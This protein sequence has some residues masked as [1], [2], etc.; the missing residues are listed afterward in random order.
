MSINLY[1]KKTINN[2]PVLEELL[3]KSTDTVD[4]KPLVY[5]STTDN[6]KS[7]DNLNVNSVT[8]SCFH[9]PLDGTAKNATCFNDK[10]YAEACADILSGCA[11]DSNKLNGKTYSEVCSDILS[12][13]AANATCFAG[14]TCT[15]WKD[16]IK[17]T[18][19]DNAALATNATCFNGCT[20]SE[21][22]TDI[23]NGLATQACADAIQNC[24]DFIQSC[25]SAIESKIPA[26]ASASNQL[27]DKDFVN[28][29]IT[30]NTANF[31]GTYACVAELPTTG[32]TNNDYAFICSLN[33]TT[34]NYIYDRYKWVASDSCWV[35]EYELNTTGFT[36]EQLASINSGI[37]DTLVAKITD[38]YDNTVTICMNDECKGSFSLNQ[39]TDVCIDLGCTI[40]NATCFNSCTYAQAKADIRNY[41]PSYATCTLCPIIHASD[42]TVNTQHIIPF[43]EY[44]HTTNDE[45]PLNCDS[46]LYYVTV[47]QRLHTKNLCVSC[48][49][50]IGS[51]HILCL[52]TYNT[53]DGKACEACCSNCAYS[54]FTSGSDNTRKLISSTCGWST[55]LQTNIDYCLDSNTLSN[56]NIDISGCS[57]KSKTACFTG[58]VDIDCNVNIGGDLNVTGTLTGTAKNAT[59]FNG[60]TYSQAKTDILSG[61]AASAT[62]ATCFG[63][64]TYACAKADFRSGLISDIGIDV[65]CG[66][67]C[68]CTLNNGST[69]ALSANAFNENAT[70]STDDYPGV[71]CTGTSN[72]VVETMVCCAK[73]VRRNQATTG[74]CHLALFSDKTAI[75]NADA[76]VSNACELTYQPATGVLNVRKVCQCVDS[77]HTLVGNPNGTTKYM[78]IKLA[79]MNTV[80]SSNFNAHL[81]FDV[82]GNRVEMDV[83]GSGEEGAVVTRTSRTSDYAITRYLPGAYDST[84]KT[85]T[86]YVEFKGY[87]NIQVTS[88]TPIVSITVLDEAP[89]GTFVDIPFANRTSYINTSSTNAEYPLVFSTCC[90]T[91][92]AGNRTLYNDSANNLMYNPS[93]NTLT[94]CC[95]K[96]ASRVIAGSPLSC[97]STQTGNAGTGVCSG[98]MEIFGSTPF[99]DFHHNNTCADCSHRL[100]ANNGYLRVTASNATGC[101]AATQSANFDFCSDGTFDTQKL[102]N[103]VRYRFVSKKTDNGGRTT[104]HLLYD[105][106]CAV[107]CANCAY[108]INGTAYS[109]RTPSNT[110]ALQYLD[111]IDFATFMPYGNSGVAN[112]QVRIY[113]RNS[114]TVSTLN[115]VI[116]TRNDGR[117]YAGMLI[118]GS[119]RQVSYD[120]MGS[121]G[122]ICEACLG[123]DNVY[124]D[125]SGYTYTIAKEGSLAEITS[126]VSN[127]TNATCFGGC[128]Y[129]EAKTDILSGNASCARSVC[130]L[131]ATAGTYQL[132][133][134]SDITPTSNAELRVSS[135]CTIA[136]YPATGELA[137]TCVK[138]SKCATIGNMTVAS[139]STTPI[140]LKC[141]TYKV[142]VDG[143]DSVAIGHAANANC[144]SSI[145][146]GCESTA[147]VEGSIAIGSGACTKFG[148][149]TGVLIDCN[150]VYATGA[151]AHFRFGGRVPQIEIYCTLACLGKEHSPMWPI[152]CGCTYCG[153]HIVPAKWIFR[154]GDCSDAGSWLFWDGDG[155]IDL[156]GSDFCSVHAISGTSTTSLGAR[157][158]IWADWPF[159]YWQIV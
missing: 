157:I 53:I 25:V 48:C 143:S 101:N 155:N 12:G 1:K 124:K 88:T 24:A 130:R 73:Q 99:I 35:C 100:I 59:C 108:A 107:C 60:K 97:T 68:V 105:M 137:T 70:I 153:R 154:S 111:S 104:I 110:A 113:C 116:V 81:D 128:T 135:A 74:T 15:E 159:T 114:S 133:L 75:A 117:I 61:N 77:F 45:T 26:Q 132:A 96:G 82:H 64:C 144:A 21:A 72:Y 78:E 33:T 4:N 17:T 30:T 94:A 141:G 54:V 8:A 142:A 91:P 3:S 134:F 79:P 11:A 18:C 5:D 69:L 106:T 138:I 90:A 49:A 129:A 29:S 37:T 158:E 122:V 121:S 7:A 27:A 43:A 146:I 92:A 41:T 98:Y 119:E 83:M 28:S 126:C 44:T 89:T 115:N 31:R 57:L 66:D 151:S 16:I 56:V 85:I 58:N 9:G 10:T 22:C 52:K 102:K 13:T 46:C 147:D 6:V 14:K 32:N 123:T 42:D 125:A 36:A 139:S 50:E 93:T 19:V 152:G 86:L 71:Y 38:V 80:V 150:V 62:N 87:R 76:Y 109:N 103:G 118:S 47:S 136:Y 127:A 51:A 2:Q 20:Y 34:G 39:N 23:R 95:V 140:S 145:A 149:Y 55:P 65:N 120:V 84:D 67:T 156:G 63:G 148:P 112:S 131:Q 40:Q